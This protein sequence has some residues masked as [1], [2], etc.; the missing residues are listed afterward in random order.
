FRSETEYL[1]V[2]ARE[3]KTLAEAD[4]ELSTNNRQTLGLLAVIANEAE[5]LESRAAANMK[6]SLGNAAE[7]YEALGRMKQAVDSFNRDG[8]FSRE[9]ENIDNRKAQAASR[10]NAEAYSQLGA[11]SAHLRD[12]EAMGS[13]IRNEALDAQL[14]QLSRFSGNAAYA[15]VI[16]NSDEFSMQ[17]KALSN[18]SLNAAKKNAD[19]L[20]AQKKAAAALDNQKK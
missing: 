5:A 6:A 16:R 10:I 7:T 18:V 11:L 17:V 19:S 20:N 4:G 15:S 3:A 2:L 14:A 8:S 13:K 12:A 9:A 1:N